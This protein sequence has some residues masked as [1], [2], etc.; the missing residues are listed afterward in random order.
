MQGMVGSVVFMGCWE[1]Q[2]T[3]DACESK[4]KRAFMHLPFCDVEKL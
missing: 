1:M 4:E 3:W 2:S